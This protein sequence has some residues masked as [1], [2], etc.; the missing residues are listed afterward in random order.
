MNAPEAL[1]VDLLE[2]IAAEP[3]SYNDVMAG[4]RTNCPKL[5]VWEDAVEL[6][7]VQRM[8]GLSGEAMVR[9]TAQGAERL[10]GARTNS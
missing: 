8:A 3:R 2:W 5:P 1:I 10:R 6:G 7:L 4:W 9:L